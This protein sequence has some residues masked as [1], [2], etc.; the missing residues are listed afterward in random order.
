M[1]GQGE[2]TFCG[3]SAGRAPRFSEHRTAPH[4]TAPHRT[5][6]HRTADR[7]R[8]AVGDLRRSLLGARPER[9]LPE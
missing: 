5:A 4:R 6:P 1:R 3:S 9:H 7:V 2:P 8:P